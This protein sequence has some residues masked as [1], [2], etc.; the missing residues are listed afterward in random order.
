MGRGT[1]LADWDC[2]CLGPANRF[3]RLNEYDS[4]CIPMSLSIDYEWGNH[5]N[6]ALALHHEGAR[7]LDDGCILAMHG[8]LG[9]T[10]A[11]QNSTSFIPFRAS[12]LIVPKTHGCLAAGHHRYSEFYKSHPTKSRL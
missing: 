5:I 3:D 7:R 1:F 12:D 11:G 9:T 2:L 8:G 10:A 4:V 6:P